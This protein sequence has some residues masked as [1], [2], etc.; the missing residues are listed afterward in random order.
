MVRAE[1][2]SKEAEDFHRTT[3]NL[4]TDAHLHKVQAHH[5]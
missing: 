2:S 3:K 1:I 4:R 5:Y